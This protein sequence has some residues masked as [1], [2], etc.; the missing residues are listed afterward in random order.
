MQVLVFYVMHNV[1]AIKNT[2]MQV[3]LSLV[4]LRSV[5]LST[6]CSGFKRKSKKTQSMLFSGWPTCIDKFGQ[7]SVL[8]IEF[9]GPVIFRTSRLIYTVWQSL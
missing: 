6:L 4:H 9:W 7:H 5:I 3:L 2:A 1:F 8:K